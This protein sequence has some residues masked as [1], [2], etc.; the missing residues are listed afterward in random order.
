MPIGKEEAEK[1]GDIAQ[2][3]NLALF[4]HTRD[5]QIGDSVK[6]WPIARKVS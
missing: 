3:G 6:V 1:P 2:T 5:I 4:A